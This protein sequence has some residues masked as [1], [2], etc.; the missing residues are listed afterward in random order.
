MMFT[1]E[2]I[3]AIY[4]NYWKIK[5]QPEFTEMELAIMEGGGSLEKEPKL[6]FIK[7]LTEKTPLGP[8]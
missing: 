4:P 6:P 2:E 3:D 1:K 5:K 8:L 7:S